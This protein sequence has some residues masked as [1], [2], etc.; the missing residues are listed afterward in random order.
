MYFSQIIELIVA[1]DLYLRLGRDVRADKVNNHKIKR[2]AMFLLEQVKLLVKFDR[3]A[4]ITEVGQHR[5][6]DRAD[7][8][9]RQAK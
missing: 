4:N 5:G 3:D 1:S 8:L 7:D 9:F 6:V 2:K